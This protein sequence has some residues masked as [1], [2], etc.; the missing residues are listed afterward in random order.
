MKT[1]E[2]HVPK[3]RIVVIGNMNVGKSGKISLI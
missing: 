2:K 1:E 3:V